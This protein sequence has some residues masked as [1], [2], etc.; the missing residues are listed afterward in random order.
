[1][2]DTA[3]PGLTLVLVADDAYRIAMLRGAIQAAGIAG[4]L[5]RVGRTQK[6]CEWLGSDA[7]QS[8]KSSPQLVLYDFADIDE[9][10]R[11]VA[12]QLAFGDARS[13]A[14]LVLLTS[15]ASE[16]LLDSG[17]LDQGRATMFAPRPL[18]AMLQKL[19]GADAAAFLQALATLYAYGPILARQPS[20]FLDNDDGAT[21]LSA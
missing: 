6:T 2:A 18:G 5:Q 3:K 1:M 8:R 16:A 19:A 20:R 13:I 4:R 10:S 11:R 17:E 7:R 21:P 9:R 12:E 15:P 14:P